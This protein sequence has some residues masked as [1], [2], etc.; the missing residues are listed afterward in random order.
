MWPVRLL[1]H[2]VTFALTAAAFALAVLLALDLP[3]F[4]ASGRLDPRIP[5]D[6]HRAIGVENWPFVLRSL[7]GIGLFLLACLA[8][9]VIMWVRR[10]RGTTHMLRGIVGAALLFAAPFV[11]ARPTIDW[12][13][14]AE[15][16]RNGWALW[17]DL[18]QAL[19]P[20]A[21]VRAAVMFA[22]AIVLLVW[23]AA[24]RRTPSSATQ[25]PSA[26]DAPSSVAGGRPAMATESST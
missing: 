16:T 20:I 5:S 15:A 1:L 10:S 19:S 25:Q 3:G 4:L 6:M 24:P 9:L 13:A 8:L 18:V 2:V 14:S 26:A 11:L 23:P 12:G 21:M 17:Q 22:G 7:G